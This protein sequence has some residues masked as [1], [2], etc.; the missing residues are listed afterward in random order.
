MP[1]VEGCSKL[2]YTVLFVVAVAVDN[3]VAVN[4]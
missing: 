3:P 2:D 4:N 1:E